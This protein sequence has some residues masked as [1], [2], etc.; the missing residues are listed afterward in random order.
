MLN[1]SSHELEALG[2]LGFGLAV[3]GGGASVW[4][5]G[6]VL[7][8][9][10]GEGVAGVGGL[11]EVPE[12]DD[13]R[14]LGRSGGLQNEFGLFIVVDFVE[15][16]K[17]VAGVEHVADIAEGGLLFEV[18]GVALE[19]VLVGEGGNLEQADVLQ[20]GSQSGLGLEAR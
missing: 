19:V 6:Q 20:A 2:S 13:G 17:V 5:F 7:V 12:V 16:A 15:S 14:L 8:E 1:L 3:E 9:H 11:G 10:E 4:S 18:V